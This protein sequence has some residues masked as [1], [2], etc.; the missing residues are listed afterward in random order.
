MG[1]LLEGS[2]YANLCIDSGDVSE[3][4]STP[5]RY[6]IPRTPSNTNHPRKTLR[7]PLR[8]PRNLFH[9]NHSSENSTAFLFRNE[10]LVWKA[11]SVNPVQFSLRALI[12][13]FT[14]ESD[15]N[16]MLGRRK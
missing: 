16:F 9:Q 4:H 6:P 13:T 14:L 15:G 3:H 10:E 5:I 12:S 2:K 7:P 8:L 1:S 11:E